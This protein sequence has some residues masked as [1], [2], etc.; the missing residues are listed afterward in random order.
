MP[1]AQIS[2]AQ[3]PNPSHPRCHPG[4]GR[5]PSRDRPIAARS[6]SQH[7]ASMPHTSRQRHYPKMDPGRRR[8]DPE[9]GGC[10]S[11]TPQ[12]LIPAPSVLPHTPPHSHATARSRRTVGVGTTGEHGSPGL[13]VDAKDQPDAGYAR[14][15]TN[16]PQACIARSPNPKGRLL[17]ASRI[18]SR[19]DGE[20]FVSS[21]AELPHRGLGLATAAC[22]NA[23]RRSTPRGTYLTP[24]SP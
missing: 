10:L 23:A 8:D 6:S 16:A 18:K 13:C 24:N 5:G 12:K 7:R 4:E 1:N 17:E 20:A 22:L 19:C 9:R 3:A 14:I 2:Q 15:G 21:I 11:A